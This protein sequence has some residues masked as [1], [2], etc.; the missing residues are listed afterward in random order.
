V[1]VWD[2]PEW[3]VEGRLRPI[4][5]WETTRKTKELRYQVGAWRGNRQRQRRQPPF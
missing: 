1:E 3:T 5:W 4:A 2:V